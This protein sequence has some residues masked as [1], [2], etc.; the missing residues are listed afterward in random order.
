MTCGTTGPVHISGA[1]A[2]V[3]IRCAMAC[4]AS[5]VEAARAHFPGAALVSAEELASVLPGCTRDSIEAVLDDLHRRGF[6]R[7]TVMEEGLVLLVD[8]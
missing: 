5:L 2:D 7:T 1:L 6:L 4:A 3:R 8:R